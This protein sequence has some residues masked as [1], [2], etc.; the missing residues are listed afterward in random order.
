MGRLRD[1]DANSR[2]NPGCR[3]DNR[4]LSGA[5]LC[6][7]D[8]VDLCPKTTRDLPDL[9]GDYGIYGNITGDVLSE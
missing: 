1:F 3:D 2:N 5:N 6:P 8:D 9:L 7:R 4:P